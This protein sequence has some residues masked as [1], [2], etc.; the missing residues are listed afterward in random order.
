MIP[1][2]VALRHSLNLNAGV[3]ALQK[4]KVQIRNFEWQDVLALAN[5]LAQLQDNQSGEDSVTAQQLGRELALPGARPEEDVFIAWDGSEARGYVHM[6]REAEIGRGVVRGGVAPTWR[7]KGV[8][9]HLLDTMIAHTRGLGLE[10]VHMDL[11]ADAIPAKRL[12]TQLGFARVRT[13]WH[14]RR[15]SRE[16][17]GAKAPSG[18]PF[19]LMAPS[20]A[21]ALTDLQNSV[22]AGSWGYAPNTSEQTRYRLF[23][24]HPQPDDVVVLEE[25][26]ALVAYCWTHEQGPGQAGIIG[27]MGVRPA[28]RG[29]GLGGVVTGAG[30]DHLLAK[31]TRGVELTVDSENPPA[32]RMYEALGF[33]PH[34]ISHW[35]E[36]RLR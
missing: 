22:F 34:W 19:R 15:E 18:H 8:G 28:Y 20:E 2:D 10:V 23:R 11:P 26:G 16:P 35:Y 30:V 4:P 3:E 14:L 6:D 17:T 25:A 31:G 5:L 13:H 33:R 7:R 32:I 24:L 12:V 21:G 9:R 29:K 36:L 1:G 27:M